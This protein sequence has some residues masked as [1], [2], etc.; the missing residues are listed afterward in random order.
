[1]ANTKKLL[2]D[3]ACRNRLQKWIEKNYTEEQQEKIEWWD[4]YIGET[5]YTWDY[6]LNGERH[7]ITVNR[8]SGTTFYF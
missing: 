3:K 5:I 8:E 6:E 1:M 2:G 4:D 7:Q